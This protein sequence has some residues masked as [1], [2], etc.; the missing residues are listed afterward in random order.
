MSLTTEIIISRKCEYLYF[1]H[2]EIYLVKLCLLRATEIS[3]R[4]F[5]GHRIVVTEWSTQRSAQGRA[6]ECAAR[7][8]VQGLQISRA[9]KNQPNQRRHMYLCEARAPEPRSS[10]RVSPRGDFACVALRILNSEPRGPTAFCILF[11]FRICDLFS[12]SRVSTSRL[13]RAP[14]RQPAHPISYFHSTSE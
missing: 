7:A 8:T 10:P 13:L 12:S 14:G 3:S 1:H 9:S 6:Q 4:Y 5:Y 2:K 11:R